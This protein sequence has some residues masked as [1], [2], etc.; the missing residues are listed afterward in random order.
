MNPARTAFLAAGLSVCS[1]AG[2]AQNVTVQQPVIG[3]NSVQ[4][5]VS[6]P[7]RGGMMVGGIGRSTFGSSPIPP[8]RPGTS[9]HAASEASTMGAGVWI[10]DLSAMDRAVLAGAE[11]P[12]PQSDALRAARIL[13]QQHAMRRSLPQAPPFQPSALP[14]ERGERAE[15]SYPLGV[16]AEQRGDVS[17]A[18]LHLITAARYGSTAAEAKLAALSERAAAETASAPSAAPAVRH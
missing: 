9:F 7:D 6:V 4:T 16:R 12:G 13:R 11:R 5:T 8:F 3:V 1:T 2:F 10:H 15:R 18:R 17:V 14:T